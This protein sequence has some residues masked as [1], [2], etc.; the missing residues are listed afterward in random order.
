MT[1]HGLGLLDLIG[2]LI[3]EL[4]A[5]KLEVPPILLTGGHLLS[6]V[7]VVALGGRTD[8]SGWSRLHD[9]CL[10]GLTGVGQGLWGHLVA[11]VDPCLI[12]VLEELPH[13]V[14]RGLHDGGLAHLL[15][16]AARV[17]VVMATSGASRLASGLAVAIESK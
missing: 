13:G 3:V 6:G 5:S 10:V 7:E 1:T 12:L 11:F 17:D 16:E 9:G 2:I 4:T 14:V 8:G 15:T